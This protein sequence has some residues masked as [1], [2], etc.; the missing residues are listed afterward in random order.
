[1][2]GKVGRLEVRRGVDPEKIDGGIIEARARAD[3]AAQNRRA[4]GDIGELPAAGLYAGAYIL[5]WRIIGLDQSDR[6]VLDRLFKR[7][8]APTSNSVYP[9]QPQCENTNMQ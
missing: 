7:D 3:R 5:A 4:G 9:T 1:L 2:L 8:G 6:A